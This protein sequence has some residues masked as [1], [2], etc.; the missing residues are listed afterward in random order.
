VAGWIRHRRV[1]ECR[2]DLADPRLRELPVAAVGAR[3]GFATPSHFGAVFK[4][5][6]GTSPGEYRDRMLG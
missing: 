2:R 1:E 3:W 5:G 4:A 6:T